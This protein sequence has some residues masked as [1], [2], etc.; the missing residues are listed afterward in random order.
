MKDLITSD[1]YKF[2]LGIT[3]QYPR[4]ILNDVYVL[5]YDIRRQLEYAEIESKELKAIQQIE[6]SEYKKKLSSGT[7]VYNIVV[8]TNKGPVTIYN[9]DGIYENLFVTI[10]KLIPKYKKVAER[11]DKLYKFL[12]TDE[13]FTLIIKSINKTSLGP[14]QRRIVIGMFLAYFQIFGKGKPMTE[15]EHKEKGRNGDTWKQ[16]L[17]GFV[18]QKLEHFH[19]SY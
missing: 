6:I 19:L 17:S 14:D 10:K 13:P 5:I 1:D 9:F 2:G 11:D 3:K 15:V 16:Y 4:L 18:K 7:K 12:S 8:N